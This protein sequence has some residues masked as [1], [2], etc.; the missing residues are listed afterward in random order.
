M[1]T[2][3]LLSR[4]VLELTT[5]ARAAAAGE[6]VARLR[7]LLEVRAGIWDSASSIHPNQAEDEALAS[8][9][10]AL[11]QELQRVRAEALALAAQRKAVSERTTPDTGTG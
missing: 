10:T 8:A 6:S 9:Q 5:C 11:E 4:S 1:L 2:V 7:G 3:R